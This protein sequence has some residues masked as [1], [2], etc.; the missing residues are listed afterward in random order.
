MAAQPVVATPGSISEQAW[1][2]QLLELATLYGWRNYHPYDSR[3]SVPGW[4]D[5]VLVRPPELLYV[6]LKTDKGRVSPA[7][8]VW[9]Y[10][11]ARCGCEVYVWRPA[12]FEQIHERLKKART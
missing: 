1:Q 10:D 7:Q 11:L 2:V 8:K 9:L 3:R 5:L 6:E 12:Q 4:P